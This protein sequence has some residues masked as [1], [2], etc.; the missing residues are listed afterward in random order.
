MTELVTVEIAGVFT[1]TVRCGPQDDPRAAAM[2]VAYQRELTPKLKAW[3]HFVRRM[4]RA[5]A[6][7]TVDFWLTPGSAR[8]I[9]RKPL[10]DV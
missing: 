10:D 6:G 3:E 1:V 7:D 5:E 8:V 4:R 9:K 2:Q